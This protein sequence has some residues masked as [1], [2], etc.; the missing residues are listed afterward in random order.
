MRSFLLLGLRPGLARERRLGA[1]DAATNEG[2]AAEGN[3]ITTSGRALGEAAGLGGEGPAFAIFC[4][5]GWACGTGTAIAEGRTCRTVAT[6]G[7]VLARGAGFAAGATG[8]AV[9]AAG[10]FRPGAD[11]TVGE[12]AFLA[13]ERALGVAS[14]LGDAEVFFGCAGL[15]VAAAVGWF[16]GT[17]AAVFAGS[18]GTLGSVELAELGGRCAFGG[19]FTW[20]ERA[21]GGV[22]CLGTEVTLG[23]EGGASG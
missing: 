11:G 6:V 4:S 21:L 20:S 16:V 22:G 15:A 1:G 8:A 14:R 12:I 3:L 17:S 5:E 19:L 13:G 2:L 18:E 10:L 23:S 7:E 9:G